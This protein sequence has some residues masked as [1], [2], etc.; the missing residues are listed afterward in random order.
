MRELGWVTAF[1]RG[2]MAHEMVSSGVASRHR[3]LIKSIWTANGLGERYYKALAPGISY[4]K[5]ETIVTD[6]VCRAARDGW[7][8]IVVPIS[9]T[10]A[11]DDAYRLD[12]DDE[13]RFVEEMA[14]LFDAGGQAS[15]ASEAGGHER[16]D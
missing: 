9:P 16:D 2:V 5:F 1:V 10:G 13:Q 14:A 12:I 6:F 7:V 15:D 11:P 4:G 3:A 8:R